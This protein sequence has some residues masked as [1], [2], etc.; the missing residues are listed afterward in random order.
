MMGHDSSSSSS[1]SSRGS[2]HHA[3]HHAVAETEIV[4]NARDVHDEDA[5]GDDPKEGWFATSLPHSCHV[6][7]PHYTTSPHCTLMIGCAIT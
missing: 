7:S 1:S 4:V 5:V 6:S 3:D 2:D